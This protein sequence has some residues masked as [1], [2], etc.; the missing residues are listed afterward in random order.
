M[1]FKELL[2]S[3]F[4][5]ST[6]EVLPTLDLHGLSVKESFRMMEQFV[7]A[8]FQAG[9]PSIR[10]VYGKGLNSPGGR[11]VLREVIPRWCEKE[12]KIWIDSYHREVDLRGGDGSI[13]LFLK[14]KSFPSSDCRTQDTGTSSNPE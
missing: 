10:V 11:G 6:G 13:L 5:Q 7:G 9:I 1:G 8:S 2:R 3:L 4:R 14:K 12:G